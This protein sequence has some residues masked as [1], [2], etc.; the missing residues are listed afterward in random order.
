MTMWVKRESDTTLSTFLQSG[1]SESLGFESGSRKY[2]DVIPFK[3]DSDGV[4]QVFMS[5]SI[6]IQADSDITGSVAITE[7]P[8]NTGSLNSVVTLDGVDYLNYTASLELTGSRGKESGS[9]SIGTINRDGGYYGGFVTITAG[10]GSHQQFELGWKTAKYPRTYPCYM[11]TLL[12]NFSASAYVLASVTSSD[13]GA[14]I[15]HFNLFDPSSP[16]GIP[17]IYKDD[18]FTLEVQDFGLSWDES[19]KVDVDFYYK[20]TTETT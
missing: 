3:V 5:G 15:Y 7:L 13:Y 17:L 2:G 16:V 4:Q 14:G 9:F 12:A 20:A 1:V 10:S 11:D 6:Q 19:Y 18:I 8:I